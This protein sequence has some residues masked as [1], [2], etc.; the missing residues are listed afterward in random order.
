MG[1]GTLMSAVLQHV[2]KSHPDW[3]IDYQAEQ[4]R[5][6]VGRG[7]VVETFAYG[8]PYPHTYYDA[9]FQIVLYDT[10]HGFTDRP[11]TRVS[12]CLR[13]H[14]GID[15]DAACGRYSVAVSSGAAEKAEV[16]VTPRAGR[17]IVH[18]R[19]TV[20][21]HY[22]GDSCPDKKNLTHDQ[23]ARICSAI[24]KLGYTPLLMDWRDTSPLPD[25]DSVRTVG[26]V[27]QAQ[28]WGGDAEM[29]AA[30]IAQC[31]A[32]VGIDSGPAKCA[33]ATDTP[34]LVVWTG[35]HPAA[36]HDPA[37]NTTHLV[38]EGYHTLYPICRDA[39][40]MRW[41]DANY[42][43]CEYRN[44]SMLVTGVVAWLQGVLR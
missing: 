36:F 42:R 12:S 1:D 3:I 34:S 25:L 18:H 35:H 16:L 19:K 31:A 27:P 22:Q 39:G 6:C 26:R 41:F 8:T 15:W 40:V 29:N 9:E 17:G 13:D 38:F 28:T 20:A 32:F 37:P 11:N 7:I 33:S 21:I 23:A 43:V 24:E 5:H 14:F 30:V 10:W 44:D 4:G 2:V